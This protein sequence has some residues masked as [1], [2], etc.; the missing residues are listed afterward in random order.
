MH[1]LYPFLRN[2]KILEIPRIDFC[3]TSRNERQTPKH[4]QRKAFPKFRSIRAK[5]R[6]KA[7]VIVTSLPRDI[8][9]DRPNNNNIIIK[10]SLCVIHVL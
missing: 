3:E 1:K 4:A 6:F 7:K 2:S 9:S 8:Y 10:F 5:I